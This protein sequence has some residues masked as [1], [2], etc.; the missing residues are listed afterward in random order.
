MKKTTTN[1]DGRKI[2]FQQNKKK[3]GEEVLVLLIFTFKQKE[4]KKNLISSFPTSIIQNKYKT[5]TKT[6]T[7]NKNYNNKR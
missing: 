6:T 5:T 7:L 3:K 1:F 4:R 2:D